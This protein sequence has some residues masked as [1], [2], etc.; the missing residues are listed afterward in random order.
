MVL[1]LGAAVVGS[2]VAEVASD[3]PLLLELSLSSND[4]IGH[5][6]G[7]ESWESWDESLR[8][9][10]ALGRFFDQ[11]DAAVGPE[12]WSA[13]LSADHG[14]PALPERANAGNWPWCRP[15]AENRWQ[16]TCAAGDRISEDLLLARLRAASDR[17]LGKGSWVLGIVDPYVVLTPEARSLPADRR[18]ELD[19]TLRSML[20]G[21]PGIAAV[22]DVRELPTPCPPET[23]ASIAAL[24]C[25]SVRLGL[26]GDYY[27]ITQ[28]GS[29]FGEGYADGVAH[30]SPYLFDRSVPLLARIPGK[31]PAGA[32]VEGPL[33]FE[34]F[35]RAVSLALGIDFPQSHSGVDLRPKH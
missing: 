34:T 23:D 15:G 17:V 11:L 22:F 2:A 29:F 35:A 7:P 26:I 28:P 33:P 27:L 24:V 20:E 25:R 10:A 19:R 18:Q 16:L 13:V 32:V 3:A 14:V 31:L 9:D 30:G 5:A 12:G 4:L 1:D 21:H 8:L 6:F